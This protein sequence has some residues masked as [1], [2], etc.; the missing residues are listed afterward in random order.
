MHALESNG[1]RLAR[2]V[3]VI[4]FDVHHGNGT[5]E[6][7]RAWHAKRRKARAR[8]A[9]SGD[10]PD[11]MFCSIHL[12]DDGQGSGIEFYPGTGVENDLHRNIVNVTVPP[13]WRGS[14]DGRGHASAGD[15]GGRKRVP[16]RNRDDELDG[17]G[18]SL[19][20]AKVAQA[21]AAAASSAGG[22][23]EWMARLR[24]R[25][26]PPIRAF[27]PDLLIISAG[28]D[29]ANHDV[30]NAGVDRRGQR[31]PGVNL[32]P[33]D[34]EE[35]T[36]RLCGVAASCGA[37]V[38][39]VLEGGYGHLSGNPAEGA[40]GLVREGLAACVVGHVRALAGLVPLA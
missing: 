21:T 5:E 27:R 10:E 26:L 23:E 25:V 32:Q 3:A 9:A 22:R 20:A 35:M 28:F 7:A 30:G 19:A 2:R 4:D 18:A 17:S 6:I 15:G 11:L 38:V 34:Y 13:M 37:K 40:A 16:K 29:A 24:E 36:A 8:A 39:S 14:G 31:L 1:G 12:A 33:D